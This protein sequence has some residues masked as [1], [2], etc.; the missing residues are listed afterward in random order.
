M[1]TLMSTE[2]LIR[3]GGTGTGLKATKKGT[4]TIVTSMGGGT[5]IVTNKGT[6]VL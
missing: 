5:K 6:D 1:E 3:Q 2:T 4:E